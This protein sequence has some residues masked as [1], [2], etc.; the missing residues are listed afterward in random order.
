MDKPKNT[1]ETNHIFGG[2]HIAIITAEYIG[3]KRATLEITPPA[4]RKTILSWACTDKEE[5]EPYPGINADCDL[6]RACL[7]AFESHLKDVSQAPRP[8]QV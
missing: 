8:V 7:S 5:L 1:K 2:F 4:G 3:E 6:G